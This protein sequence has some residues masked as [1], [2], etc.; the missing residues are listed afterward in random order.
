[1]GSLVVVRLLEAL[2][3]A[4][5]LATGVVLGAFLAS[6]D[7]PAAARRRRALWL[8]IGTLAV[9]LLGVAAYH[10]ALALGRFIPRVAM[11]A[12]GLEV[13]VG[14]ATVTATIAAAGKLARW[15][16]VGPIRYRGQP[17]VGAPLAAFGTGMLAYLVVYPFTPWVF[18]A[19]IALAVLLG[20]LVAVPADEPALSRW[21]APLNLL[22][23]FAA[24]VAGVAMGDLFLML[25][26]VVV[27]GAGIV[28]TR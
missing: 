20:A 26:G 16:P 17:F 5:G 15:L 22:A 7:T 9:V 8:S 19:L 12:L 13:L 24:A 23:G 21:I 25:A 3:S 1:M 10:R 2:W 14:A 4:A 18:H 28:V 27:T 11:G 6:G